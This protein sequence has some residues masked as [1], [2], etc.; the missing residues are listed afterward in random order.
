MDGAASAM[1]TQQ[2]IVARE[3]AI[4]G[5]EPRIA[6]L[7]PEAFPEELH[8]MREHLWAMSE[9]R[10]PELERPDIPT[11]I[12]IMMRH[13]TLFQ[14]QTEMGVQLLV[15]GV[16]PG[17]DRELAILRVAWLCQAPYEWGE[18]VRFA[19]A[20]GMTRAEVEAII[21]G[22]DAPCWTLHE[23]AILN[24]V[25]ELRADAMVSDATWATLAE[26][27]DERQ[28]IEL[29]IVIGQYQ[30]VAYYQNSLRIRLSE[31]NIGLAAR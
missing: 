12:P 8:A 29:L 4:L 11:I 31:G 19:H 2:D 1:R 25:A 15:D 9:V 24:A 20:L 7:E 21:I 14:R 30:A 10:D 27:Y 18:H 5:A 22:P 23:R 16:L 13:P 3:A 6:P 26:R 17:R 28:L